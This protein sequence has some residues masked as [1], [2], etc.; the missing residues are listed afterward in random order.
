MRRIVLVVDLRRGEELEPSEGC[1]RGELEQRQRRLGRGV[2]QRAQ[3][4]PLSLGI[5]VASATVVVLK[6]VSGLCY[7][8]WEGKRDK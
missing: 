5:V 4:S 3:S 2:G 6:L 1:G 8:S 7:T